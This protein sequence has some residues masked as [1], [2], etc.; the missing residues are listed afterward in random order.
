MCIYECAPQL[1]MGPSVVRWWR[2]WVLLRQGS[3]KV[4]NNHVG[5]KNQTCAHCKNKNH[6]WP[7]SHL[8]GLDLSLQHFSMIKRQAQLYCTTQQSQTVSHRFKEKWSSFCTFSTMYSVFFLRLLMPGRRHP[9]NA[10]QAGMVFHYRICSPFVC[11]ISAQ[12]KILPNFP[13]T[14]K[15]K[16]M[17]HI[18]RRLSVMFLVIMRKYLSTT[19]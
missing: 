2:L 15:E 14:M 16:A 5:T 1:C 10:I 7:L 8:S 11:F 9:N 17:Y 12:I 4:V 19:A 6:S 13:M 18:W 3:Q